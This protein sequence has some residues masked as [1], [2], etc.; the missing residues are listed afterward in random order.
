MAVG[1]AWVVLLLVLGKFLLFGG[2]RSILLV[3]LVVV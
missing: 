3:K 1:M 2:G